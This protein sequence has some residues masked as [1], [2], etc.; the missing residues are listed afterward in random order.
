MSKQIQYCACKINLAGQNCHTVIYGAHNAVT[1]PEIQV[2]QT[3]H[4][5][6]NVMDIMPIGIGETWP[7]E[8]KNRLMG[9]YGREVVERCFPGRAFRMDYMMTD[10]VNLPR[11]EGGQ[12]STKE[13]APPAITNGNGDD[14]EDD[15]G[16]DEVAKA[17]ASLEPIFRPR[18]RRTPPPPSE[19]KEVG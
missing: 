7:T 9:I 10:E 2:L 16:E 12:I 18:G 15:D 19:H 6:E 14:E 4:G 8:E 13:S 5:D 1:W 11:Y 3:L 17:Q